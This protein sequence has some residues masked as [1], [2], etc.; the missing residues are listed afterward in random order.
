M[1]LCDYTSAKFALDFVTAHENF[2]GNSVLHK[3]MDMFN[4]RVAYN[5]FTSNNFSS[6]G[7]SDDE[8]N[9][10]AESMVNN[11]E[12]IY[13]VFDYEYISMSIY[14]MATGITIR[15]TAIGDFYA[16][17]NSTEPYNV[18]ETVYEVVPKIPGDIVLRP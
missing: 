11:G 5:Y 15:K 10:I 3:E 13:I 6:V 12:L 17:T 9:A 4:N 1:L 8:I 18:P 2:D 7:L 16:Y 14:Y